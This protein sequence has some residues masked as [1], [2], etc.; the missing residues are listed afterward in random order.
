MTPFFEIYSNTVDFKEKYGI[1]QVTF[2]EDVEKDNQ[3]SFSIHTDSDDI[4][5]DE[6]LQKGTEL[7]FRFGY[8]A[9][10]ESEVR[11]VEIADLDPT[12]PN[13]LHVNM[14]VRAYD[15]GQF[16][17]RNTSRKIWERKTASQIATEI[18]K[19]YRM[20]TNIESTSFRY[21][22]L[23]QG[24]RSDFGLLTYLAKKEKDYTFYIQDNTLYFLPENL[25]S[26][27]QITFEFDNPD[28]PV[29]RF[30][31]KNRTTKNTGAETATEVSTVNPKTGEGI[32][33]S[34]NV[35]TAKDTHLNDHA[36]AFN[37]DGV[38]KTSASE[39][40]SR[41]G[42]RVMTPEKNPERAKIE[43][44]NAHK[45][46]QRK[47]IEGTLYLV[48][49]PLVRAGM[50]VTL[51]NLKVYA[52]NWYVKSVKHII[53][54]SG[55]TTVVELVS[56]ALKKSTTKSGGEKVSGSKNKTV[57]ASSPDTRKEVKSNRANFDAN[58]NP[59]NT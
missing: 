54:T 39:K 32:S 57:G 18:A 13:N 47:A 12:I 15:K 34:V 7:K 21:E 46:A 36:V 23:P 14:E 31:P 20:K 24:N 26:K 1:T 19:S 59:R 28:S 3:L 27:S 52:G 5:E 50:I 17:K 49:F 9:G 45:K 35:E 25:K 33:H 10:E 37:T 53:G 42:Q 22:Q 44:E 29:V 51:A 48:G 43:T 4:L 58:A 16:I 38:R 6:L 40:K 56:N 8:E 55:F 2:D 41:T 30:K 11:I